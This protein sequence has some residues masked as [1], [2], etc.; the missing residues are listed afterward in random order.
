MLAARAATTCV[1][2]DFET[3]RPRRLTDEERDDPAG[4]ADDR[5]TGRRPTL[6]RAAHR[7]VLRRAGRRCCVA[8]TAARPARPRP[9]PARRRRGDSC[10]S[11]CRSGCWS[12]RTVATPGPAAPLDVTVAP[13]AVLAWL[14]GEHRRAAAE[15]A[16]RTGAA[17]LPPRSGW[18]RIDTVPDD[19]VRGWCAAARCAEGRRRARGRAGRAAARRGRR[20]AA[21]L[22]RAHRRAT[23]AQRAEVTLRTLSALTRMG[24][25]PRGSHIAVD[26]AGRWVR[27]AA[28]YGIGL[29]RTPRQ[30][31]RPRSAALT[32]QHRGIRRQHVRRRRA[33]EDE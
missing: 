32:T 24:F 4:F 29:R 6:D 13:R 5:M 30:P 31:P 19:V 17:A 20:R 22:G 25:L 9:A 18:R 14:D 11:G 7:A 8:A 1:T 28:E 15:P 3:D 2:F 33:A 23:T 12:S 16:T 10:S 26:V 21:R 27:V